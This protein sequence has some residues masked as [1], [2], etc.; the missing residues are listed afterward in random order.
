[1]DTRTN[2]SDTA[3]TGPAKRRTLRKIARY[4]AIL[5]LGLILLLFLSR[6]LIFHH[7]LNKKTESFDRLYHAKLVIGKSMIRG[8]STVHLSD[9]M[10][11]PAEGDTLVTISGIDVRLNL[12]RLIFG[13]IDLERISVRNIRINI[14][15]GNGRSNYEFLVSANGPSE[16]TATAGEQNLA[17]QAQ[18]IADLVFSLFPGSLEVENFLLAYHENRNHVFFYIS[19]VKAVSHSFVSPIAVFRGSTHSNWI[20]KGRMDPSEHVAGFSLYPADKGKPVLPFLDFKLGAEVRVDT[21]DFSV[22]ENHQGAA[23]TF[24][25]G[26]VRIKGLIVKQEKISAL[27]VLF[28]DLGIG[29]KVNIRKDVAELDSSSVV[30]FNRIDFHPYVAYRPYPS[31]RIIIRIHKPEFP[32]QDLFASLPEGL[33]TE[34]SGIR[35][36]GDL[37]WHLDFDV[38]LSHP[39][40]MLFDTELK[41]H[42][43]SVVSYGNND[44]LKM[45]EPFLYTAY[46][47]NVPVRTFV[48]GPENPDFRPIEKISPFLR[49]AV[50]GSEDAGFYQHRGFI[51]D[52]FRESFITDIKEKRF[53]R[54]GSTITMQLVKNVFLNRNKTLA[55]KVEEALIVW[56]IENQGLY[57]KD[58]MFEVYLNIIEWGPGIY[59]AN[60]ASRFYF[61]KDVSK[62][63]LA[64]AIFMASIIPRPKWFMYSF[65][66]TGKLGQSSVDF[67][68]LLLGKMLKREQISEQEYNRVVPE[69]VLKGPAKLMLKRA[70][71][72]PP[73]TL[74]EEPGY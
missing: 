22:T 8:I 21:V 37:S 74:Q 28:E 56:L 64:E 34:V 9:V 46:E 53:A 51:P 1:M 20:F 26:N 25:N 43:F 12:W 32:A 47:K 17:L 62:L 49:F 45:N 50:L 4:A 59:G 6:N 73:D 24:I 29:Y 44:L 52:A 35:V 39:D 55:R 63:N 61:A 70:D 65:D 40:S 42:A 54:G 71:T 69:V 30:I 10:L 33:F 2:R 18:R 67:I 23:E 58:R 13:R 27:P 5:T 60:E 41:R 19:R 57:S 66:K 48:V 68:N 36:K 31:K 14:V 38:D 72:V 3:M 16:G 11:K 15:T 7:Y